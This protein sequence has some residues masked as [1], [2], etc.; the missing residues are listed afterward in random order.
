[1]ELCLQERPA[2]VRASSS[3]SRAR[4]VGDPGVEGDRAGA[5]SATPPASRVPALTV[6]GERAWLGCRSSAV[7]RASPRGDSRLLG[8]RERAATELLCGSLAAQEEPRAVTLGRVPHAASRP[9]VPGG[10]AAV[11]VCSGATHTPT[12]A[13]APPGEAGSGTARA[14]LR[15]PSAPAARG[16]CP[17]GPVQ[18]QLCSRASPARDKDSRMSVACRW[19]YQPLVAGWKVPNPVLSG[20]SPRHPR[21]AQPRP[22]RG[23]QL[24][25]ALKVDRVCCASP[26]LRVPN[27][28]PQGALSPPGFSRSALTKHLPQIREPRWVGSKNERLYSKLPEEEQCEGPSLGGKELLSSF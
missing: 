1:M 17:R 27:H 11:R 10:G 19:N 8:C 23:R 21:G 4:T 5:S 9:R 2:G 3:Q 16:A 13:R 7:G 12:P 20:A 15:A 24:E 14:K 6:A 18:T 25:P 28:A 26:G 22:L